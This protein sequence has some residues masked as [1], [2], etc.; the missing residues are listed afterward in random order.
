[1]STDCLQIT[2]PNMERHQCVL[3]TCT[4]LCR[5][6]VRPPLGMRLNLLE[7]ERRLSTENYP[8]LRNI[9]NLTGLLCIVIL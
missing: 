3:L 5:R 2:D 1:M 8:A 7:R 9:T 4:L 6:T